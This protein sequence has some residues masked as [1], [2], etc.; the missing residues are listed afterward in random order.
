MSDVYIVGAAMTHFGQHREHTLE[1][2]AGEA[3][4]K[5]LEDAGCSVGDLEAAYYTGVTNGVMQDQTSIPG[6]VVFSKI[7]VEGIPVFNVENG[8]VSGTSGFHLALQSL[9]AG[10]CDVAL[11]LG[12]EKMHIKDKSRMFK[13]FEGGWDVANVE[14]NTKMLLKA[15]EGFVAPEGSESDRPYSLFMKIYASACINHMKKYGTTQ[16]QIAAVC[17]KNHTHSAH[18]PLAQFQ[19]PMTTEQVLAAPPIT[20]PLT[21]PMCSPISDGAAAV[22]VCSEDGLKRIGADR[23]RTVRVAASVIRSATS[24]SE[25]Q[26][27]LHCERLAAMQAYEIAGIGPEEIDVAEVHDATAAAEIFHVENLGF[28][29]FG[30]GGPAAERGEFSIGGRLPVN[31]SGGLESKGHPIGATGLAQIYE[32]VTQLRGEAGGRQVEGARHALHENSGGNVGI[33]E[34]A[35]AVNIFSID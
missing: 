29:P 6:Q 14:K 34:A 30:E 2:M 8:C 4:N 33:E 35:V 19:V 24:R 27:E 28:V 13:F 18:N 17:A 7:G 11:V 9:K 16:R 23:K 5:A 22:I 25:D 15:S 3:L 12:A 20:Y 32:L 21:M 26:P 10:A 31:P 1:G